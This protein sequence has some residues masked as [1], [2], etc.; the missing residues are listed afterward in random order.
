MPCAKAGILRLYKPVYK[1]HPLKMLIRRVRNLQGFKM[2][3]YAVIN[4]PEKNLGDLHFY[5]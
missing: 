3:Y 2:L 5:R 1:I 4:F